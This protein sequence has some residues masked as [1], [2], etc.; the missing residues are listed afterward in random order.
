MPD[1]RIT[2]NLDAPTGI[3]VDLTHPSSLVEYLKAQALHLA[4][5]PDF[6]AHKDELLSVVAA[7]KPLEFQAKAQNAFQLGIEKPA[8]SI[9]PDLEAAIRVNVSSGTNLFE[10]DPFPA[11]ATVPANT[12]YLSVAI[13]GALEAT[14]EASSGD[15]TFG[16]DAGV[17]IA[18]EYAKA[19]PLGAGEVSLGEAL[20]RTLSSYTIPARLDD[21]ALAQFGVNDI[22]TA[23]GQGTLTVSGEVTVTVS[24]NP[25]ASLNLPLGLGAIAVKA[26]AAAGLSASFAI[27][28][29]YQIRAVRLDADTIELSFLRGRGTTL[30]VGVSGSG[31]VT[32]G[33]GNTDVISA[34]LGAIS[35]DPS[36]DQQRLADL[37]PDER[38][39]LTETIKSSIDHN[40]QASLNAA[41]ARIAENQAAFQ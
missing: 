22:A 37:D 5:V 15:L 1:I 9:T 25:L 4:V 40:L 30:T 16:F 29:A 23:S 20:G 3:Q 13:G 31:G 24:P 33:P 32:A 27:S 10:D 39:A 14:A 12:G 6:L 21:L 36:K 35:T 8:I 11:V 7:A 34:L 38:K 2:D 17:T 41:L 26:G 19:F 18:L 28:G